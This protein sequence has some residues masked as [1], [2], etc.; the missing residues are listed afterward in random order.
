MSEKEAEKI[1][2]EQRKR[3]NLL[4]TAGARAAYMDA[5]DK[6]KLP[7]GVTGEDL[8]ARFVKNRVDEYMKKEL[9]IPFDEYIESVLLEKFGPK[10]K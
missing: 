3:Y 2:M 6:I 7:V 5:A 10:T 8:L 4:V 9:D 1:R